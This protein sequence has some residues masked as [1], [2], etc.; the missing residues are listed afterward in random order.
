MQLGLVRE[1]ILD[2]QTFG[3]Q[4]IMLYFG[5]DLTGFQNL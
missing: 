1:Y 4:I 5:I 2:L 3:N